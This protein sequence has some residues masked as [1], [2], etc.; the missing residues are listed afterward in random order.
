M[1]RASDTEMQLLMCLNTSHCLLTLNH[2]LNMSNPFSRRGIRVQSLCSNQPLPQGMQVV[3]CGTRLCVSAQPCWPHCGHAWS[4]AGSKRH[5]GVGC[6][7]SSRS[8]KHFSESCDKYLNNLCS[9]EFNYSRIHISGA[10]RSCFSLKDQHFYTIVA[11][12]YIFAPLLPMT[13]LMRAPNV[14]APSNTAHTASSYPK[15][16]DGV[17]LRSHWITF[18]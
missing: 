14:R 7:S 15:F 1:C 12:K 2:P 16:T 11:H 3:R 5:K 9:T 18:D 17:V 8:L 10:T 13:V 6:G 4:S